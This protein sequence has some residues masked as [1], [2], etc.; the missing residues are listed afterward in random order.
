[1]ACEPT[2]KV[3]LTRKINLGIGSYDEWKFACDDAQNQFPKGSVKKLRC[4]S[5]ETP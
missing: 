2:G 5:A 3:G 4:R 1:M